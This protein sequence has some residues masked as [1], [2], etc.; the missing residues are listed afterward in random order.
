MAH[1]QTNKPQHAGARGSRTYPLHR[2][3]AVKEMFDSLSDE[4]FRPMILGWS[5]ENPFPMIGGTAPPP[6]PKKPKIKVAASASGTFSG[7]GGKEGATPH[8]RVMAII[9]REEEREAKQRKEI[10]EREKKAEALGYG[11]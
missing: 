3:L 1:P 8:E 5:G 6:P 2:A 9:D 7:H 4:G 10:V 11:V